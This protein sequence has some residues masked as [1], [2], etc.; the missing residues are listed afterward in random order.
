M[1]QRHENQ[2]KECSNEITGR[3]VFNRLMEE[4][5]KAQHKKKML[6]ETLT[7]LGSR[8]KLPPI[9]CVRTEFSINF[10][11]CREFMTSALRPK[12]AAHA[13]QAT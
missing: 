12:N 5:L 1:Q 2:V 13:L 9:F 7:L 8:N 6:Q 3:V 10:G 4:L 11:V